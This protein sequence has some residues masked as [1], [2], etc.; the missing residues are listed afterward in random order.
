MPWAGDWTTDLCA[1][2]MHLMHWHFAMREI[3]TTVAEAAKRC[4]IH[5]WI[6]KAMCVANIQNEAVLFTSKSLLQICTNLDQCTQSKVWDRA[7]LFSEHDVR[8]LQRF[9]SGAA[10][11]KSITLDKLFFSWNN[12]VMVAAASC[13]S[14][15]L[16]TSTLLLSINHKC[17]SK[18]VSLVLSLFS[19]LQCVVLV[20]K[21][22]QVQSKATT[23]PSFGEHKLAD[24]SRDL[25]F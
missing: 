24:C 1:F 6:C 20:Q 11:P 13:R 22:S 2:E 15:L 3:W 19:A 9:T 12:A 18:S 16:C 17:P 7:V 8:W 10:S 4:K 23:I 21:G 14:C 5:E 25:F